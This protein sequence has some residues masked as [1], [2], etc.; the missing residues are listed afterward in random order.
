MV[1]ALD[2]GS[3]GPGSK[4][5]AGSLCCVLVLKLS[6]REPKHRRFWDAND[7]RKLSVPFPGACYRFFICSV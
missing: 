5:P 2:S 3:R 4:P 6:I 1:S 7:N